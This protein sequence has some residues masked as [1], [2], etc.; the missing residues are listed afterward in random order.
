MKAN[1]KFSLFAYKFSSIVFKK[2]KPEVLIFCSFILLE[3]VDYLTD[4]ID[5]VC[6]NYGK[7]TIASC[8]IFYSASS[9]EIIIANFHSTSTY[10]VFKLTLKIE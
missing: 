8:G 10:L 1:M 4:F 9:I 7:T 5:K 2:A 3:C 6:N